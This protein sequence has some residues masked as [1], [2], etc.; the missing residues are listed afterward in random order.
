MA[1]DSQPWLRG[2]PA[3][4][5]F[6]SSSDDSPTAPP[7]GFPHACQAGE[8]VSVALPPEIQYESLKQLQHPTNMKSFSSIL[9]ALSLLAVTSAPAKD[10]VTYEGKAGPGKGKHIVFLAGDEEYRSEE[11]LPMLA[12]ILSQRHGFKCTVLFAINPPGWSPREIQEFKKTS[13]DTPESKPGDS[14]PRDGQIDP[15]ESVNIPGMEQLQ[16]ADLVVMLWRF[17]RPSD[18]NMKHFAD[19][20]LAGK[21]FIALRTSTHAFSGLKGR[22]ASYNQFGKTVL[23]EQWV[24]H[25]GRHKS[26]ATLGIIE[27]GA[28]NNPIL[29]GVERVFGDTDVYEAAPPADATILVRGQVLKGMKPEDAPADYRKRNAK[30]V[31]QGINDPMMPVVWVRE[32]KNESGTVNKTVTTTMGSATD[33]QNEGLR[34][35]L[36]NA[37]YWCVGLESKIPA[38]ADVNYVGDYRPTMYGFDGGKKGVKPADHELK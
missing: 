11:G 10:W 20:H 27:A 24:N 16:D 7:V 3:G 22:F 28:E 8:R 18:E 36:V 32:N 13:K 23:G 5:D 25:W 33:L 1:K 29:R 14:D 21:P 34:R 26:E 37:A 2:A 6:W 30:G 15:N 19:Y 9:L 12:K 17:R 31:E 38:K 4:K 35:L